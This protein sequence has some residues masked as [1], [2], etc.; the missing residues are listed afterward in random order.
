MFA[1]TEQDLG[2]E[3]EDMM[4]YMLDVQKQLF[5]PLGLALRYFVHL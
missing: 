3:S 4:E 5:T 1:L 2:T